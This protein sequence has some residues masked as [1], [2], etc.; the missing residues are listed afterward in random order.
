MKYVRLNHNNLS[1]LLP[2][3][4]LCV[5]FWLLFKLTGL[6]WCIGFYEVEVRA[7]YFFKYFF[8]INL[9]FEQSDLMEK[10]QES[11]Y[12]EEFVSRISSNRKS[13]KFLPSKV[14]AERRCLLWKMKNIKL[15]PLG[16]CFKQWNCDKP[17][18]C[19]P[20]V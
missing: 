18:H 20:F 14:S 1:F 7:K 9:G 12:A 19:H 10:I 11:K 6:I 15:T 16:K 2:R 8:S 17:V 4:F 13:C 3:I 5:L